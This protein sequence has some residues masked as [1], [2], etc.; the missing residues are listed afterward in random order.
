[1]LHSE[2]LRMRRL[3]LRL[4]QRT[5]GKK[6]GLDQAYIS[7]LERGQLEGMTVQTLESLADALGVSPNYLL[8][9]GKAEED[10]EVLVGG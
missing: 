6:I 1:M 10:E 3:K 9:R 7:K 8:G 5:L 2:R 4:S